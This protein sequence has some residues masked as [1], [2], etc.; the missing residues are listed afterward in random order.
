MNLPYR[1]ALWNSPDYLHQKELGE[2]WS[3]SEIWEYGKRN[4]LTIVTKDA[5]FTNRILISDPPPKVIHMRIGNLRLQELHAFLSRSWSDVLKLSDENKL[6]IIY[7]DRIECV[8]GNPHN[9]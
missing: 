5:D 7:N 3:D 8:K 2:T 4:S 6:V 9:I 1:F